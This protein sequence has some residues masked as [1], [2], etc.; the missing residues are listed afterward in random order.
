MVSVTLDNVTKR[1]GDVTAVDGVS[2]R[3]EKGELFFLLGP[4][5]CGKTTLLRLIAGFYLPD[6]GRILFDD[7]DV[8]GVPPHRRNT[9][10]VFQNYA[11]WPHMSVHKNVEYGLTVRDL[12]ADE[13]DRR[14]RRALEMV[15]METY[16]ERSPNQLSGG[17][18]Q[19]VALARALVIEP[20]AVLLDEPLS[21]LDAKLRLEMREQ[22]RRLHGDLGVTMIY[23][24]HDQKEALSMADRMAVLDAGR[25]AQV[26]EPRALYTRPA[27]RFVAGFIG[28]T[29]FIEGRIIEV[30]SHGSRVTGQELRPRTRDPGPATYVEVETAVGK[31]VST[32]CADGLQV[33]DRVTCSVLPEALSVASGASSAGDNALSGRVEDVMYLGEI[34]QYFLKLDDGSSVKVVEPSPDAPKARVGERA[35]VS[36]SPAKVIVLKE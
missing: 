13:R 28:E 9:G 22:I 33:G 32:N 19:R 14:V 26:G 17:Q 21:N 35:G 7:R 1:F 3:V 10:M 34:E 5:G 31:I 27:S 24:T 15:Q 4:S 16:A 30:T 2:L 25:V 29:N 36:F 23:V 18:Q 8:S 6:G 20:D 11:L 12:P